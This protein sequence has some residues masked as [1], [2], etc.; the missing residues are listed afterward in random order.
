MI[1]SMTGYGKAECELALKKI[2]IEVKSLNSKQL[3]LNTRTPGVYREK[4]IEIRREISEKL[5]RGK[6]DFSLYSESLGVESNSAINN[7]MVKSYFAQLSELCTELG[8][9]VNEHI[10]PV[11]M[12]LPDVV[13]TTRDE[14][15]ENEWKIVVATIREALTALDNFRL[16]EGLSLYKDIIFNLNTITTLLEQIAP[17]ELERTAKVK[18]RILDG[19]KELSS[20]EGVDHNRLEQEMIFYLEKLDINEEKVRLGHH[21]SYFIETLELDEPVGK[22]LG[23]IAQEIGR[24]IN[25]LGSKANHTE[26]Q[27]LVIGMKDALEKIKE[28]LLNAL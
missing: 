18:E 22:K 25:T 28:Q 17:F 24:E 26:M 1:R 21:C 6:V 27:K 20:P 10:L 3:D 23:F 5:I 16:Q 4:E 11:I 12:Q 8:L 14:P 19:L 15:D 7:P 2:T 9:P 13:K